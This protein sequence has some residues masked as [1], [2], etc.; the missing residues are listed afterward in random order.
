MTP[1]EREQFA[2]SICDAMDVRLDKRRK[3]DDEKHAKH[4]A[5]IDHV[6]KQNEKRQQMIEHMKKTA[7]GALTIAMLSGLGWIGQKV[8]ELWK[9]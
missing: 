4:H 5:Y 7:V 3:I 6:I 2:T 1:E 9:H 8:L